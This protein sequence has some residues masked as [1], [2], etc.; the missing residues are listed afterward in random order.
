VL[1]RDLVGKDPQVL[2]DTIGLKLP[3][4]VQ[5]LYGETDTKNPFVFEEQMMP[6]VPFV[7]CR[8][9]QHGIDL[10]VEFEHGYGHTAVIHSRNVR[11][12]T[13]M[14]RAMNT[15]LFIKNG[16]SPA[17]LGLGGEGFLSYSI[18]TPTGEGV[19]S[20]LTFTRQRRCAMVDDLRIF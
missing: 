16:P 14:A 15:T 17:G 19:T 6:F 12:M 3:G 13:T 20:P 4:G 2:A 8:D 5:L 9:A 10:C 18:A 11:N 1:N 7:R